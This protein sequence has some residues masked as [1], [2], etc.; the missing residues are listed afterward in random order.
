MTAINL[1]S[2]SVEIPIFDVS[3]FSLRKAL[4]N[5][6]VGGRFAQTGSHVIVNALNNISFDA[7]DGDRVALI[8]QNGSGKSTLLRVLARVYPPTSG[9]VHV[10]GRVSPMFD[11]MLGMTM[12][13]TG[14]ENI[15]TCGAIWG[16]T[17]RKFQTVSTT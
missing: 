14:L 9:A 7:K 10:G 16:L 2:V 6:T 5:R 8:G 1:R 4:F 11:A 13:A 15:W 12:D 3:S 17:P